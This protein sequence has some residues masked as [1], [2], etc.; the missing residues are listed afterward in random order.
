M[1]PSVA[2]SLD[3]LRDIHLPEPVSL[4]P[5]APGLCLFDA[6]ALARLFGDD[7]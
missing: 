4:W 1:D 6:V 3:A 7:L 2:H 5:R